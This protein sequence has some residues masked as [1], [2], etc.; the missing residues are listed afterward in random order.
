MEETN[1]KNEE[2]RKHGGNLMQQTENG[3][4]ETKAKV[5]RRTNIIYPGREHIT[6]HNIRA[7]NIQTEF[8]HGICNQSKISKQPK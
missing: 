1:H 7:I 6:N 3:K 8:K 4:T 2:E 5:P